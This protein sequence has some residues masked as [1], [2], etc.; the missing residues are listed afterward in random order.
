MSAYNWNR[1]GMRVR[2]FMS[3]LEVLGR[4]ERTLVGETVQIERFGKNLYYVY[5]CRSNSQFQ[6]T[7]DLRTKKGVSK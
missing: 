5:E 7:G 3:L 1:L 2:I 4:K 6:S